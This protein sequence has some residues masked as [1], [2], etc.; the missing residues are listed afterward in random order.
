MRMR[1][2]CGT[3][4]DIAEADDAVRAQQALEPL[5]EALGVDEHE[6]AGGRV[7]AQQV[8]EEGG[9]L[10]HRRVVDHLAHA[11]RG[12]ALGLDADQLRVVHVLVGELEH[13]V[14]ERR[15]EQQVE[16]VLRRRQPAQQEADVLDEAEVEH[17]VGLVED[18]HLHVPQVEDVLAEEVDGAARRADQD[19]DARR[20]RA[21]LLV[22]VDAAEGEAEREPGVLREDLGVAVDLDREL[23]RRREHQRARRGGR[24]VRATPGSAAGA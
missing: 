5:G 21:A 22:V 11:L 20:E 9:L 17:A 23:A 14:R 4:P 7:L 3:S 16:A 24:P 8:D 13:A 15:R 6:R 18:H 19:V 1:L 10:L 2:R 12:D